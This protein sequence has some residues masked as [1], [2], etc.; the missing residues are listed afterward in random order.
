MQTEKSQL[1]SKRIM[2][3]TRF[4]ESPALSIDPRVVISRSTSETD[5][6]LF[7]SPIFEQNRI[8]SLIFYYLRCMAANSERHSQFFV[9]TRKYR[10]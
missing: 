2:P 10:L 3:D 9:T 1:E 4:T 6:L 5:D 7:F 8:I